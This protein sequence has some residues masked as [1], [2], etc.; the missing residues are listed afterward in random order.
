MSQTLTRYDALYQSLR[1]RRRR[2]E[3]LRGL[4][5]VAGHLGMRVRHGRVSL[6]YLRREAEAV[7]TF[8]PAMRNHSDRALD[9]LVGELREVFHR[10]RQED[11][12]VRRALAAIR[13]VARRETSEEPYIVQLM[14]ALALYHGRI[15]EMLTGEGKTLT[16]SLA[17]P[18]LA[19]RHRHV[20]VLTVNDYLAQRDAESR[21][22]IYERCGCS[23]G[24]IVQALEPDAR[25]DVY[26]RSIVYGTPKQITADWLRD[27]IRL[28]TLDTAW[29]GR[30]LL[31][32]M[33]GPAGGAN[34]GPMIP[35]LAAALVDEADAVL[36]DE[37][38]VPLIIARARREDEMAQIYRDAAELAR[39]LDEKADYR[40]DYVQRRVE[41]SRR[42]KHRAEELAEPLADPIWRAHRRAEELVRQALVARHCYLHGHQYQIVDGRVVI[43]DEYT[44]RFLPDRSWEHGLHQ[45]VEAKE[46]LEITADRE[47]LARLSFQRFFRMY[48]VLCGM[49]GT[50][51]D[52]RPEMERVYR[53]PITIIPTNRPIARET[54][55][56]RVFRTS[57]ARW[58]AVVESILELN[59]QRRPVL[60]GSRSIQ[61][62]ELVSARLTARGIPHRVLN[63]NFDKEEAELI[64]IAGHAGAIT[65]A[66]NM[67]GRGTDIKPDPA[68]IK[69]GGLHVILSEMHSAKRIDRQ[70]IG[71]AGRQGDP[72][73]SQMFMAL[74]D[75]LVRL[76][77]P[78]LASV[79][80][81]MAHSEELVGPV[82]TQA[83][84]LFR[85]AQRRAEK[86]GRT[87]RSEVLRQ[88]DWIDQH[89]P[90]R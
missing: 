57:D 90:G 27:Q 4:D 80:R 1:S 24:A 39:R 38:V 77:A 15:V 74:E 54:W 5:S 88:D 89:L 13:E 10:G 32:G 25:F 34:A 60:V 23:V 7:A 29:A 26:A 41:L 68:S 21:R 19:W 37:G 50:V 42:G 20:H 70:F 62:S 55:E 3:T 85:L 14:G 71:R 73:S 16:G 11:D 87:S 64:A 69:A 46:S 53:R 35:G 82:R 47:T 81:R 8:E 2:P 75:E 12:T 9:H 43:V 40:V 36:I 86:R 79:V 51:A 28:G 33:G 66:T 18:L 49:T 52:A 84:A 22:C 6:A 56:P 67:A 83:V 59:R 17:A 44:G 72:G 65:V 31:G 45:A 78:R 76:H 63:A 30:R 61:A 48:P 58:S